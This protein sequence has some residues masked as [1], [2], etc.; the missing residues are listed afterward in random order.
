MIGL[1]LLGHHGGFGQ[2]YLVGNGLKMN[3]GGNQF[4]GYPG[5]AGNGLRFVVFGADNGFSADFG[6]QRG[7]LD[8][9]LAVAE[10]KRNLEFGKFAVQF[11]EAL[12]NKT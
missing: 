8:I 6:R 5:I 7:N 4:G 1:P 3:V 2:Q 11:A 12:V 10:I 9:G